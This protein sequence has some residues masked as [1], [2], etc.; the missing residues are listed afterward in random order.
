MR[1]HCHG[2]VPV[3]KVAKEDMSLVHIDEKCPQKMTQDCVS[4]CAHH[5]NAVDSILQKLVK[6]IFIRSSRYKYV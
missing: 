5:E 3:V 1:I 4:C 6:S 2:R